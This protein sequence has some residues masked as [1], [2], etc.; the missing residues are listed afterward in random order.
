MVTRRIELQEAV[1]K[2]LKIIF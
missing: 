1:Q 2:L